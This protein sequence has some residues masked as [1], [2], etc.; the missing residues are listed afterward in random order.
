MRKVCGQIV[1]SAGGGH[2]QVEVGNAA[3]AVLQRRQARRRVNVKQIQR[4]M[5]LERRQRERWLEVDARARALW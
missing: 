2:G 1:I 5:L 3:Q 4:C